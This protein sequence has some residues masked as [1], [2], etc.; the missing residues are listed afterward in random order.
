MGGKALKSIQTR[1]CNREEFDTISTELISILK[2][3]FNR[4]AIPMFYR[5]KPDFGDID[6]VVSFDTTNQDMREY[7]TETFTPNEIFHNGSCWSFDYKEIQIDI[8][9]TPNEHFDSTLFY[10]GGND[11]GNFVGR[12]AHGFSGEVDTDDL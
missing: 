7:I 6:I 10:M 3:R 12:I 11:V 2:H 1:R 5:N 9:L 8:I 4:V